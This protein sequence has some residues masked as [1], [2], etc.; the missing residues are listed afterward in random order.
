MA[1][2]APPFVLAEVS[3][4][5]ERCHTVRFEAVRRLEPYAVLCTTRVGE[6]HLLVRALTYMQIVAAITHMTSNHEAGASGA[7]YTC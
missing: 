6:L 4:R 2:T 7:N 1:A 5:F 3:I